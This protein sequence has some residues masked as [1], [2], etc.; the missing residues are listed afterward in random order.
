M[1][2][3][4]R[5]WVTKPEEIKLQRGLKQGS[6]L[7]PVLFNIFMGAII[8]SFEKTC[9]I[10][11]GPVAEEIGIK[12]SYNLAGDLLDQKRLNKKTAVNSSF[13]LLDVLYADDCVL[14]SNSVRAMQSMVTTTFDSIA[15]AFG[16]EISI[17]KT[18][19]IC[20]KVSRRAYEEDKGTSQQRR[21]TRRQTQ[22]ID[23]HDML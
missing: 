17:D 20:N 14:C 18:K 19:V 2:A 15:T 13:T 12:V 8:K 4:L 22:W 10:H 5:S 21:P 9:T 16:M 6:V 1:K 7:S 3:Q 11:V 23:Y